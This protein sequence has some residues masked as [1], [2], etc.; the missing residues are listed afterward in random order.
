MDFGELEP[1]PCEGGWDSDSTRLWVEKQS[2]PLD[3]KHRAA[4]QRSRCHT[5]LTQLNAPFHQLAE[6]IGDMELA[7]GG[8][9]S[10]SQLCLSS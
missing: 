4:A 3:R 6:E 1:G 8:Q 10:S 7:E 5:E 9:E 2:L